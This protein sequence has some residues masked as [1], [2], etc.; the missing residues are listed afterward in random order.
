MGNEQPFHPGAYARKRIGKATAPFVYLGPASNLI[1]YQGDQPIQMIWE[2]EHPMPA[3][4]YEE[5]KLGG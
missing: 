1:S 4:L 2:L 3:W 5:A